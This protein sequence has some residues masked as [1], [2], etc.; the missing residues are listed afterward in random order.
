MI[1]VAHKNLLG[2]SFLN[3]DVRIGGRSSSAGAK[4][5]SHESISTNEITN[6]L[7]CHLG[8]E[9]DIPIEHRHHSIKSI[10]LMADAAYVGVVEAVGA[11]ELGSAVEEG[12][13]PVEGESLGIAESNKFRTSE[14]SERSW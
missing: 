8:T 2:G 9:N 6:I 10:G 13:R 12:G 11:E 5:V 3:E 7:N 14:R 4:S 1:G